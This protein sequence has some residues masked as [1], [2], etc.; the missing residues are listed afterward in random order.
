MQKLMTRRENGRRFSSGMVVLMSD[1]W[2]G[3]VEENCGPFVACIAEGAR[4]CPHWT[5]DYRLVSVNAFTVEGNMATVAWRSTSR[6]SARRA[7][8]TL[9]AVVVD[10][11]RARLK[12]EW[13]SALDG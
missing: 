6:R 10:Q 3:K 5:S 7:R 13:K 1:G 12:R 4:P 11:R 2:R 8:S 9:A